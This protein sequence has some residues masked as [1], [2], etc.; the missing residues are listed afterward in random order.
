MFG[1]KLA[2]LHSGT[3]TRATLR[4]EFISQEGGKRLFWSKS[5]K[6]QVGEGPLTKFYV[7]RAKV[8][9]AKEAG[10]LVVL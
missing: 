7:A 3:F 2:V 9:M 4:A 8:T 6:K 5:V 1:E 10:S